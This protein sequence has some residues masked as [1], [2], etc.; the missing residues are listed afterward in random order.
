M[1]AFGPGLLDDDSAMDARDDLMD[2]DDPVGHCRLALEKAGHAGYLEHDDAHAA[3]V[4]AL[5]VD[6]LLHATPVED[7][8]LGPWIDDH[9]HLDAAPLR[10]AAARACRRVLE[11]GSELNELWSENRKLHPVWKGGIVALA[12]RL[13]GPP[14][15]R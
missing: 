11:E 14:R 1:G 5:V 7:D 6:A 3:L 13:S 10:S 12:E 15:Q 2:A 4:A 8:R 9:R